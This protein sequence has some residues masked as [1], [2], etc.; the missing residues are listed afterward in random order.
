M[1]LV[2][3]RWIFGT[4]VCLSCVASCPIFF[5]GWGGGFACLHYSKF[6]VL[7]AV[8]RDIGGMTC[9]SCCYAVAPSPPPGSF[10]ISFFSFSLLGE[11]VEILSLLLVLSFCLLLLLLLLIALLGYYF[12][13]FIS[14]H[15]H[16]FVSVCFW[17]YIY[18]PKST[19][20]RVQ[21][22][23]FLSLSLSLQSS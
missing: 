14:P 4:C 13:I 22:T 17:S 3:T 9:L 5:L 19:S 10:P 20:C 8:L 6:V 2:R 18:I 11:K 12:A 16:F 21:P 15:H 1:R 7:M 23:T